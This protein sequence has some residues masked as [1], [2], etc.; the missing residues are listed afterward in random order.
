MS[1]WA[2]S[3][4]AST[5]AAPSRRAHKRGHGEGSIDE[6]RE[7]LWRSRLMVGYRPDGK[8]DRRTVYGKTRGEVQKKLA[9]LRKRAEQ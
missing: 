6:V 8:P 3:T 5:S 9:D 7:G 1:R 4:A 2:S